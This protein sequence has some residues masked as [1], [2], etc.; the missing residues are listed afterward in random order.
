[1]TTFQIIAVCL[2]GAGTLAAICLTIAFIAEFCRKEKKVEEAPVQEEEI[3]EI[4]LDEMLARL[5]E[6]TKKSQEEKENPAVVVNV[7]VNGGQSQE[8]TEDK[9]E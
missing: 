5:E 1:M 3:G 8:E 4:D 2:L 7:H 6:A 9:K